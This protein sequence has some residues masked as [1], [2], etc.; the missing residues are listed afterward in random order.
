MKDYK[1]G[2]IQ[3]IGVGVK[4][5]REAWNWYIRMFGIDCMIFEDDS[6]ARL[7]LPYTGGKPQRRHAIMA[8]NLQSGGGFEIWQHKGKDPQMI[9]NEILL[10]DLGILACK[11]KVTSIDKAW[12]FF[13]QNDC[14]IQKEPFPDPT[15]VRT[16]FVR[17]PFGNIFQLVEGD[18]WFLKE[19]KLT[20]G[21]YGVIIGVSDIDKSLAIYNDILGYDRVIYDKTGK[22]PDLEHLPGGK[23]E[24]RRILLNRSVPFSGYFSPIFGPSVIELLSSEGKPGKKIYKDRYWGDPGFIHLCYDMWGM[25]N[26]REYCREKGFPFAVD[27]MKNKEGSS[28]DMG[29]AAGHFSYIED[30]DGVLIEFVESHKLPISKKLGWYINLKKRNSYKPLPTW[31]LKALR[32]SRVKA[33]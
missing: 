17:D 24:F 8:L 12:P 21:S 4:N 2:G 31:M 16:F 26:L 14:V 19:N 18:S 28:F 1:L 13:N 32:L 23:G 10:G 25:D 27:S 5:L 30:P 33:K 3:Q 20:G 29:E 7:M 22:F 11:I 6:E 9:D 15:G